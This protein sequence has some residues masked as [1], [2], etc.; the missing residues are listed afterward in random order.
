MISSKAYWIIYACFI[1]QNALAQLQ[2]NETLAIIADTG[3]RLNVLT[4]M[5]LGRVRC[6]PA[7]YFKDA[8]AEVRKYST[9]NSLSIE[10]ATLL[11][12]YFEKEAA[13]K[14]CVSTAEA[15]TRRLLTFHHGVHMKFWWQ[16]LNIALMTAMNSN[17]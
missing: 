15:L 3:A 6:P 1:F 13:K 5:S 10:E 14:I 17:I 16:G 8:T 11:L 9:D 4:Y 7:Q 2:R 12:E